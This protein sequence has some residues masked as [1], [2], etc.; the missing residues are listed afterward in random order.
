MA[1][2]DSVISGLKETAVSVVAYL[3]DS[4]IAPLVEKIEDDDAFRAISVTREE[5]AVCIA[6]GAYLANERGAVICQSSGMANTFNAIASLSLPARLPFIGVVT[7]RGNLGEFNI[8]QV[9]GGYG[10]P[11]LLNNMGVRNH[12]LS[13]PDSTDREIETYIEKAA[14]T[15]FLTELPYVMLMELDMLTAW[16]EQQ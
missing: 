11:F 8:A 7:R 6:G 9:P 10:L 3:P 5:Q 12:C 1:W 15:A 16:E 2:E 13:S 14:E 4:K